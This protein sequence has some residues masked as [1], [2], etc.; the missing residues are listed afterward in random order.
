MTHHGYL[1]RTCQNVWPIFPVLFAISTVPA[2]LLRSWTGWTMPAVLGAAW[3]FAQC[4][5]DADDNEPDR[6][7]FAWAGAAVIA[8]GLVVTVVVAAVL[9]VAG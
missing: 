2:F 8:L 7:A 3:V 4:V 1:R 6:E 5:A 9:A